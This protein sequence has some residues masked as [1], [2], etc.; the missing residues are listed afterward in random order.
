MFKFNISPVCFRCVGTINEVAITGQGH[1]RL[2]KVNAAPPK[3]LGTPLLKF[4]NGYPKLLLFQRGFVTFSRLSCLVSMLNFYGIPV[5]LKSLAMT[6]E[7]RESYTSLKMNCWKRTIILTS[8]TNPVTFLLDSI[9]C[10]FASQMFYHVLPNIQARTYP[11]NSI[12][13]GLP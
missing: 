5:Y 10:I 7:F 9:S 13:V 6:R 12:L 3:E 4:N 8:S 2:C 1:P 11:G